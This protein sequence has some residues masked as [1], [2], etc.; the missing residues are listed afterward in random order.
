MFRSMG[1][2]FLPVVNKYNQVV[3]TITRSDLTADSLAETMLQKGK[4]HEVRC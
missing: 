4:K 1:L 2:R 3:G